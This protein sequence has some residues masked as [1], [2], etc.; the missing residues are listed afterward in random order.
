MKKKLY[1]ISELLTEDVGD[2]NPYPTGFRDLRV[3]EIIN[4]ELIEFYNIE[5]PMEDYALE[6]LRDYLLERFDNSDEITFNENDYEFIE[7]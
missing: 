6:I 3:Y 7:L 2:Y 5:H 1:Y 4:G